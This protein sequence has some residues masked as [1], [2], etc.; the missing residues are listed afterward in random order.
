[1]AE[2]YDKVWY[3]NFWSATDNLGSKLKILKFV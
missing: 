1:M 3:D 2:K